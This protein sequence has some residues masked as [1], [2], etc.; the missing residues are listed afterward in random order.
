MEQQGPLLYYKM[1]HNGIMLHCIHAL[2]HQ[3]P[4][5]NLGWS[6]DLLGPKEWE[7]NDMVQQ[8]NLGLKMLC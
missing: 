8:L 2:L 6:Y 3:A 1:A 4:T 5:L 7:R